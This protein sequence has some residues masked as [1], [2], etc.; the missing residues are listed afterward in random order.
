MKRLIFAL[1]LLA[2][3]CATTGMQKKED[4]AP[5]VTAIKADKI[6]VYQLTAS[7]LQEYGFTIE[8]SDPVLGN[9]TTN[10]TD[11]NPGLMAGALLG[12]LGANDFKAKISTQI[13][14]SDSG[15]CIL[16]MRGLGQYAE[17]QGLFQQ[18]KI[19]TQPVRKNTYTYKKMQ[20]ISAAI[21]E[22]AEK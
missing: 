21:K 6:K 19:K 3:A 13:I 7:K 14:E 4:E 11:L 12:S 8:S 1:A 15:S 2:F 5:L 17:D 9:I 20:E 18:D 22:A 10:Y 16:T